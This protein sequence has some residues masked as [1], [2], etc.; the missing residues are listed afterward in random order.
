[1][2][3]SRPEFLQVECDVR[4]VVLI[5]EAEFVAFKKCLQNKQRLSADVIPGKTGKN[6]YIWIFF[7]F[8]HSEYQS[9]QLES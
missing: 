2:L 7:I 8:V 1:M 5:F 9:L 4:L 6:A 3:F